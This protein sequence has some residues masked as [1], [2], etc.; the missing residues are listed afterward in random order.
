MWI[1]ADENVPGTVVRALGDAGHDVVWMRVADPG[2]SD[3]QVVHRLAAEG[4]VL[5]T[6]DK[7]DFG[8]LVKG[9]DMPPECGVVLSGC[10]CRPARDGRPVF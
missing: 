7:Q 8:P 3:G 6:F 4:R 9:K 5:L 10:R 1:F 2:A